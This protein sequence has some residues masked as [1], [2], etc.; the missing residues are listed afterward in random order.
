MFS[1]QFGFSVQFSS[2]IPRAA[3][4]QPEAPVR[5]CG[6]RTSRPPQTGT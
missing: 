1:V 3:P 5:V 6:G 4:Q 2:A